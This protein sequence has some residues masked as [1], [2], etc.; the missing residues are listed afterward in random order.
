MSEL[1][2]FWVCDTCP[3]Y[4]TKPLNVND[5]QIIYDGA[6]QC[7]GKL[8]PAFMLADLEKEIENRIHKCE[9]E[10]IRLK[11]LRTEHDVKATKS[12]KYELN[13]LLNT[14]RKARK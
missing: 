6:G 13:R 12:V 2:P 8:Q 7:H 1:V 4:W 3:S 9:N 14:L 5:C 11:R 10:V